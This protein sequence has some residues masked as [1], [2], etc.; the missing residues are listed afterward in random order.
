M[1]IMEIFKANETDKDKLYGL[2]PETIIE[3]MISTIIKIAAK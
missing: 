1:K 2:T 3:V